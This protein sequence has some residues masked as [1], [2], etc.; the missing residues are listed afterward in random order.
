MRS[1]PRREPEPIMRK[2]RGAHKGSRVA[3]K[4]ATIP[5]SLPHRELAPTAVLLGAMVR[6]G[7]GVRWGAR[8][9]VGG[10]VSGGGPGVMWRRRRGPVGLTLSQLGTSR[11][12]RQ[13]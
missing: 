3:T 1:P 5:P 11:L 7:P 9:Q 4:G 10:Q 6:W 12:C 2:G 13:R 8:C